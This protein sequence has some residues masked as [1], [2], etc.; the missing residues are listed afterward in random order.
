MVDALPAPLDAGRGGHFEGDGDDGEAAGEAALAAALVAALAAAAAGAVALAEVHPRRAL[1]GVEVAAVDDDA[2]PRA[3]G[4]LG[5]AEAGLARA[6]GVLW[7]GGWCACM[8]V[9]M[10]VCVCE[11]PWSV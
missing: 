10:S 9:C 1:L 8:S 7:R 2:V 5:D 3:E 6:E 11:C 4:L